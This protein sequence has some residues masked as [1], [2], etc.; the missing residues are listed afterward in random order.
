MLGVFF[1]F[2]KPERKYVQSHRGV[3]DMVLMI[4]SDVLDFEVEIIEGKIKFHEWI[5]DLWVVLFLHP[6]DFMLV[7]T[8]EFGYMVLIK[9]DFDSCNMK[10]I[11]FLVDQFDNHQVW[12][13]DI[14]EI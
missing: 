5:G 10:I 14:E 2:V 13:V 1:Y 3:S 11:G 12:A 6:C 8:I 4:G 7:C 9:L